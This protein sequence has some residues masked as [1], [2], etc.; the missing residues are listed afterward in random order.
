MFPAPDSMKK[1]VGE[2]SPPPVL[3][4]LVICPSGRGA[5]WIVGTLFVFPTKVEMKLRPLPHDEWSHDGKHGA[6]NL[7]NLTLQFIKC[8]VMWIINSEGL[9]VNSVSCIL[10]LCFVFLVVGS[11]GD[12]DSMDCE[13]YFP[14]YT[15]QPLQLLQLRLWARQAGCLQ[16][17]LIPGSPST[18]AG[19][20]KLIVRTD[21]TW[22]RWRFSAVCFEIRPGKIASEGPPNSQADRPAL[23]ILVRG[24]S[25]VWVKHAGEWGEDMEG[26]PWHVC[27]TLPRT[28]PAAKRG[29]GRGVTPGGAAAGRAGGMAKAKEV[30]AFTG[31][32]TAHSL[33]YEHH[34][35]QVKE[36][37]TQ[38]EVHIIK[39]LCFTQMF[40]VRSGGGVIRLSIVSMGM[41]AGSKAPSRHCQPWL[42]PHVQ[43]FTLTLEE[44]QDTSVFCDRTSF[45]FLFVSAIRLYIQIVCSLQHI[46]NWDK[47]Q[48]SIR[49]TDLLEQ[50]LISMSMSRQ[51]SRE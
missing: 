51:W 15:H 28:S 13:L 16:G 40:L 44:N 5:P 37:Q 21:M 45:L 6:L 48:W 2:L 32:T 17:G 9:W 18:H 3:L 24:Q 29:S 8:W 4:S 1:I 12:A 27:S 50:N 7:S 33:L 23:Q 46:K 35:H 25:W 19:L 31:K 47:A 20:D 39:P 14:L 30:C 22:F 36:E 10:W 43:W 34:H 42:Q 26:A 41:K 38:P 49:L 11:S